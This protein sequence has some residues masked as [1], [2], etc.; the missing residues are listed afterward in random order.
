[1][2]TTTL[3]D[4]AATVR[5][6]ATER[7]DFRYRTQPMENPALRGDKCSYISASREVQEGEGCIVG[8]ALMRL[9]FT[10]DDLRR[11][12]GYSSDMAMEKLDVVMDRDEDTEGLLGWI[13]TVQGRQD[14]GATWQKAVDVADEY[15]ANR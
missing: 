1:M 2:T 10:R 11:V 13:N 4:I 7:P 15:A 5:A 6:I 9:G 3:K 12:E 14:T 8:Q